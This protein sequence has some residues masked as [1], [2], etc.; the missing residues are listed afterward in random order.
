MAQL[1][2]LSE[3]SYTTLFFSEIWYFWCG[4]YNMSKDTIL[5]Q[6]KDKIWTCFICFYVLNHLK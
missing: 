6:K 2:F 1:T 3:M 4:N 5:A